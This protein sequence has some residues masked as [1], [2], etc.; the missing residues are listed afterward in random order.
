[1]G[2]DR[3]LHPSWC[4]FL[5]IYFHFNQTMKNHIFLFLFLLSFFYYLFFS[6]HRNIT[7]GSWITFGSELRVIWKKIKPSPF[8]RRSKHISSTIYISH[9]FHS[10]CVV[11]I[12]LKAVTFLPLKLFGKYPW[13]TMSTSV[14]KKVGRSRIFK[15]PM[16]QM[17]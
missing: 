5:S 1:M 16:P 14:N 15:N 10:F 12:N 17:H 8:S 4:S 13:M 3:K 6:S 2:L 7:L 11:Q 9:R